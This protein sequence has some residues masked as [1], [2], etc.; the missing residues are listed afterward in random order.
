MRYARRALYEPRLLLFFYPLLRARPEGRETKYGSKKGVFPFCQRRSCGKVEIRSDTCRTKKKGVK[1]WPA[2]GTRK[3]SRCYIRFFRW[4]VQ[5]RMRVTLSPSLALCAPR[6]R[7][8]ADEGGDRV[9]ILSYFR[10]TGLGLV[11]RLSNI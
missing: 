10:T 11:S 9:K 7:G 5:N 4:K 3:S 8:K 6:L 1:G 2:T